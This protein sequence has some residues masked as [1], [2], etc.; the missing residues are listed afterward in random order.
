MVK[1]RL[2]KQKYQESQDIYLY[3]HTLM[4]I[5]DWLD[6]PPGGNWPRPWAY[7]IYNHKPVL[8]VWNILLVKPAKWLSCFIHG[9]YIINSYGGEHENRYCDICFKDCPY[10]EL[11]D[12]EK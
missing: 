12:A 7:W 3:P 4:N 11:N 8:F 9:H 2:A 5:A 1:K 6:A 10:Q